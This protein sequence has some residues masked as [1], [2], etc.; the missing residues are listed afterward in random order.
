LARFPEG[1]PWVNA[2]KIQNTFSRSEASPRASPAQEKKLQRL[3]ARAIRI[4]ANLRKTISL[5]KAM[6]SSPIGM[7]N[8]PHFDLKEVFISGRNHP[9]EHFA[10]PSLSVPRSAFN[11]QRFIAFHPLALFHSCIILAPLGFL[12]NSTMTKSG[13]TRAT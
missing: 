8:N 4:A 10:R 3:S 5:L 2:I 13:A 7:R 6:T 11:V 12:W 1:L 9:S